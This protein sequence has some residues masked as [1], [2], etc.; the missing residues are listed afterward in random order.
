MIAIDRPNDSHHKVSTVGSALLLCSTSL[1]KPYCIMTPYLHSH[2]KLY[3]NPY[4]TFYVHINQFFLPTSQHTSTLTL[5]ALYPVYVSPPSFKPS[6][7]H[8]PLY[9]SPLYHKTFSTTSE[10]DPC[11]QQV[12]IGA[13][14]AASKILNCFPN[15][16]FFLFFLYSVNLTQ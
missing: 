16:S 9:T 8:I 7:L 1:V 15:R 6:P 11:H 14:S 13:V 5:H 3:F 12:F 10:T 4:P 2:S